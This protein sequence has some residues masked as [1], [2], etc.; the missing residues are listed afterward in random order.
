MGLSSSR[1]INVLVLGL[2][3]AGK[4]HFLD[5]FHLGPDTTKVPTNGYYETVYYFERNYTF[6]LTEYGGSTDWRKCIDPEKPV[7]CIF[8]M[9]REE[10][11][12]ME[13][14]NA[15]LMVSQWYKTIPVAVLW[16]GLKPPKGFQYP[17]HRPVCSVTLNFQ[18]EV[19]WLEKAYRLFEW[20]VNATG[21]SV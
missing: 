14:N 7:H 5:L 20:T 4:T 3:G 15:L 19:E 18:S 16:N 12:W 11:D 10:S 13:S 2:S 17:R 6:I 9:V 8:W 21:R 1:S